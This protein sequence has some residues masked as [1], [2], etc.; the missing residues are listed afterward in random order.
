MKQKST[1]AFTLIEVL[2][3]V[4]ILSGSIVYALKIHSENRDQII[5]ISQRNKL[6]LQDSLFLARDVLSYNKDTK[7]AYDVIYKYF[8][9]DDLKSRK[10]LKSISRQYTIPEPIQL[11]ADEEGMP[12][13]VVES[14][15]IKDKYSSSYYHFKI[16]N[17]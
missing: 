8:K 4:I 11:N 5:Y 3:S 1:K 14:I 16:S 9:I 15:K 13:A 12:S 6:S 10:I 17:F 2:V 7:E